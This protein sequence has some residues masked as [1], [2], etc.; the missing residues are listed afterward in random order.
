M[1]LSHERRID[2]ASIIAI[3]LGALRFLSSAGVLLF[4]PSH[5]MGTAGIEITNVLIFGAAGA[6]T[7]YFGYKSKSNHENSK[8]YLTYLLILYVCIFGYS[9]AS[10][11]IGGQGS[12][13]HVL[14][15]GA[16]I[17]IF[18]VGRRSADKVVE[19]V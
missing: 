4:V 8:E 6:V 13:M 9:I 2:I 7:V 10:F 5:E 1:T 18:E 12:V 15:T 14:I 11:Q 19:N 17:V 3:V 16:A